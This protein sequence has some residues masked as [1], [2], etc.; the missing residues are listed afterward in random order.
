MK[1]K[2]TLVSVNRGDIFK[3]TCPSSYGEQA[4]L[5]VDKDASGSEN[6]PFISCSTTSWSG[7]V[8]WLSGLLESGDIVYLG[9]L[10]NIAL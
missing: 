2:S 10:D 1:I 4:L 8:L 7:S 5:I 6:V 3:W 9:T